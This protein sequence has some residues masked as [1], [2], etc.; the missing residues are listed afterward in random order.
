MDQAFPSDLTHGQW[1]LIEPLLPKARTGGRPRSTNLRAVINA[2]FYVNRT[3][4]QW[5]YLPRHFPPW[6]TVYDYYSKW[7]KNGVWLHIYFVLYFKVRIKEGRSAFPSLAIVDSQSARAHF[8]E[9]RARDHFKKVIGRKRSILVDTLGFLLCCFVHK[10]N[11]QDFKGLMTLLHRLP[12]PISNGLQKIIGDQAYRFTTLK[13]EA[14]TRGI[15][16]ETIDRKKL[17]TNMKPKRWIVERSIAWFNH[18]RRLTRDY[19]KL[20]A[21]SEIMIFISQIQLLLKRWNPNLLLKYC[22]FALGTFQTPSRGSGKISQE[23]TPR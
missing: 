2:V 16:L 17:G 5:R 21:Q 4:C 3:G 10:A 11:D 7:L 20:C 22:T 15:V 12:T 19:E 9:S 23:I 6:Q 14:Q 18:Y 8:G 1:K 13:E